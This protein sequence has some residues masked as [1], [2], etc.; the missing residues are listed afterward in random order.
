MLTF[1]NM[2]FLQ[3]VRQVEAPRDPEA[4]HPQWGLPL[5]LCQHLQTSPFPPSLQLTEMEV[6]VLLSSEP[7]S[8]FSQHTQSSR[9]LMT[10]V[11]VYPLPFLPASPVTTAHGLGSISESGQH[12]PAGCEPM[13]H[14]QRAQV[15]YSP[16][17]GNKA[18]SQRVKTP[19]GLS[20]E[21]AGQRFKAGAPAY[22]SSEHSLTSRALWVSRCPC[23]AGQARTLVGV[24]L[25]SHDTEKS[26][27]K[28]I[29]E[30]ETRSP[31]PRPAW[32]APS[33]CDVDSMGGSPASSSPRGWCPPRG[34]P[35][36]SHFCGSEQW[37]IFLLSW[38]P[39]Q[40]AI[41]AADCTAELSEGPPLASS[42]RHWGPGWAPVD[43][44]ATDPGAS[45]STGSLFMGPQRGRG[46][47]TGSSSLKGHA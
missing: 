38:R 40:L 29:R 31:E 35:M 14:T 47:A 9:V 28:C 13:A 22:P 18:G 2:C 24:T 8:S 4:P 36:P 39:S 11:D 16:T 46:G 25:P 26:R 17:Q 23:W 44:T 27:S 45:Q 20:T 7:F 21:M 30:V 42:C 3:L 15:L 10:S 6:D 33:P 37:L 12:R 34:Q 19:Q 1:V 32:P 41:L 43:K 5:A